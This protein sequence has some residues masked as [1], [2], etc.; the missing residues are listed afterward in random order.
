MSKSKL[1]TWRFV[2]R[3]SRVLG[4]QFGRSGFKCEPPG[5]FFSFRSPT[6][7]LI[8]SDCQGSLFDL[9]L[10]SQAFEANQLSLQIKSLYREYRDR[11]SPSERHGRQSS[12][13]ATL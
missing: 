13:Y 2:R 6:S 10:P 9:I 12:Q 7:D 8:P 5:F 4:I 1:E 3:R 11:S